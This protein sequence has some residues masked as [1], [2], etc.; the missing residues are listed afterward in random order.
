MYKKIPVK[1]L[2]GQ[3]EFKNTGQKK[4]SILEFW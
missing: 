4:F 3:E 1:K 2:T